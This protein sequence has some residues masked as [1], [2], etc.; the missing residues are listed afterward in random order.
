MLNKDDA[1]HPIPEPWR[2][3]FK[4]IAN[5][6]VTGDFLLREHT[7]EAVAPVGPITARNM[8]ANVAAYGDELAPLNYA[9][10]DHSIY[11][12]MDGYWLMLVDLSTK[13]EPVSDLTLHAHLPEGGDLLLEIVSLHVP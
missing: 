11:R 2:T 13:G 5:A 9:T 10:W 1:E 6:F 12:W 3:T 7:I 4:E 8:A